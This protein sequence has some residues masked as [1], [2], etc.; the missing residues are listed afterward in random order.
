MFDVCSSM[1]FLEVGRTGATE[2]VAGINRG[3]A[4]ACP[5]KQITVTSSE[6]AG[7]NHFCKNLEVSRER[8]GGWGGDSVSMYSP[9]LYQIVWQGLVCL[10][11]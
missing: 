8:A 4:P 9:R 6:G 7:A 3:S 5:Q 11:V 1:L 2:G 10:C